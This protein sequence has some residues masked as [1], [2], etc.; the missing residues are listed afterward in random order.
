M[1]SLM[2]GLLVGSYGVSATLSLFYSFS[3][4]FSSGLFEWICPKNVLSLL[5]CIVPNHTLLARFALA[6][7]SREEMPGRPSEQEL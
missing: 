3:P 2:A 4:I 7:L 6:R 5:F 1:A